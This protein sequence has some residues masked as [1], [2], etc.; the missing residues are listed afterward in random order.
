MVFKKLRGAAAA[1]IFEGRRGENTE[2]VQKLS[3][4]LIYLK[5]I[6]YRDYYWI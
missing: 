5:Y 1:A 4:R 6:I 2:G 3:T